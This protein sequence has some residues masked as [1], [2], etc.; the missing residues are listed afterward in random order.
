MT[1]GSNGSAEVRRRSR[2]PLLPVALFVAA[3]AGDDD[4]GSLGPRPADDV[5]QA[6]EIHQGDGQ[7]AIAGAAV[8]IPV[9]VRVT[10]RNGDP[11]PNVKVAFAVT[12]GGGSVE[13]P[14]ALTAPDG[15]ASPGSWRL[16]R[17][18]PQR[19]RADVFGL[20]PV[21]VRAAATPA[22]SAV[23]IV[24]GQDQTAEVASPVPRAPEVVVSAEDGAPVA[25]ALVTFA[26]DRDAKLAVPRVLTDSRGRASAADWIL[27][28][29]AGDYTLAASVEGEGIAGNPVRFRARAT[30]GPAHGLEIATGDRQETEVALP[31][32]E[33]VRVRVR[34]RYGNPTP[35]VRVSFAADGGSAVVPT[36]AVSDAAGVASAHRWVLGPQPHV[37]YRLTASI[38][39]EDGA[40]VRV[41]FTA[42]ATPAAYR[43]EIVYADPAVV[44][45]SLEASFD[46]A[47]RYWESAVRGNLPW[48]TV[49]K[50]ALERCLADNDVAYAVQGDRVVDDLLV[51]VDIRDT[52]PGVLGGAGPCQ[53][54]ADTGLPV[55]GVMFFPSR[56]S[57]ETV[58]HEMAHVL[59]FGA[60][61]Q[62]LGL[63]RDPA[64]GTDADPRFLGPEAMKSFA[65]LRAGNGSAGLPVPVENLGGEG[66]WNGHWRESVFGVELMTGFANGGVRNPISVLTLAS[67]ADLG[68]DRIDRSVAHD[69]A[70]P[71]R[72]GATAA[73]Q[74]RGRTL[75]VS[76]GPDHVLRTPIAVV[77]QDGAV[78][79]Y[80]V[81]GLGV[82]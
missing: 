59:G 60:L 5:P 30:P 78:V 12:E 52:G 31:V 18:G 53:I 72:S 41:V 4:A 82:P 56:V 58:L 75:P 16:G 39:A 67:L 62:Y 26:T 69:Y 45:D 19:M 32:P 11:L 28:A 46:L 33:A 9:Q 15:T 36:H 74:R 27:G 35:G 57:H 2:V 76:A 68:Y 77:R 43:I 61:W 73:A 21:S 71:S 37:S 8:P 63:L 55:V 51:F 65:D 44:P 54:R 81:P 38:V 70:L 49:R 24:A 40:P 66:I 80:H 3:C 13:S 25:G 1:R 42:R 50:S 20:A 29:T 22:P 48:S 10:G 14:E 64:G 17:P 47:R 6:L 23:E 79:R 7:S 34:D